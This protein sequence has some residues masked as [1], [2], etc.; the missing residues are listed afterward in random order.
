MIAV[1]HR[2]LVENVQKIVPEQ[3]SI[4]PKRAND[5]GGQSM[6]T[7]ASDPPMRFDV[8]KPG[9]HTGYRLNPDLDRIPPQFCT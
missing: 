5:A 8:R 1:D 6:A 2:R 9:G 4:E 7:V 3:V